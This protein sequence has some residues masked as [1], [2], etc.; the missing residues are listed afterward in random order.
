MKRTW[1]RSFGMIQYGHTAIRHIHLC[2]GDRR[3]LV[4]IKRP[5]M[6]GSSPLQRQQVPCVHLPKMELWFE[7]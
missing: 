6:M 7:Y 1:R 2:C 4:P 3:Q 5:L